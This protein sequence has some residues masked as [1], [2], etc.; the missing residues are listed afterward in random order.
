MTVSTEKYVCNIFSI[1]KEKIRE[2]EKKE[3]SVKYRLC[4]F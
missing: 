4:H 3:K 1:I 2:K